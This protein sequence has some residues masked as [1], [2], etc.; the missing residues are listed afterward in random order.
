MNFG[1]LWQFVLI[2]LIARFGIVLPEAFAV[3]LLLCL[4]SG[5]KGQNKYSHG[6]GGARLLFR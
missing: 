4:F 2:E 1:S 6:P 5:V 3:C